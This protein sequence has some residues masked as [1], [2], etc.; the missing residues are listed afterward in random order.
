SARREH[1]GAG[2]NFRLAGKL[3]AVLMC[4]SLLAGAALAQQGA[5]AAG[6]PA[7]GAPA[8]P[9]AKVLST[10]GNAAAAPAATLSTKTQASP[11]SVRQAFDGRFP[12]LDI[13][14]VKSTPF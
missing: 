11:E 6:V 9:E 10:E 1:L 2:M 7:A 4:T 14:A 3:A 12:G 8:A 13:A 5:P